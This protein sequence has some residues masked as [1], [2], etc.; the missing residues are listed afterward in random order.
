M[1]FLNTYITNLTN[2]VLPTALNNPNGRSFNTFHYTY[3]RLIC[4][5]YVSPVIVS[6]FAPIVSLKTENNDL[7]VYS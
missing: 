5:V 3:L 7:S 4:L 2:L 1:P 6:I